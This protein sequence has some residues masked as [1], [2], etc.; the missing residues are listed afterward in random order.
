MIGSLVYRKHRNPGEVNFRRTI[1]FIC[2]F[3][4]DGMFSSFEVMETLAASG[5]TSQN[6]GQPLTPG[7]LHQ[8]FTRLGYRRSGRVIGSAWW[9]LK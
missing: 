4:R 9:Y 6:N 7:F 8:W 2:R 3:S 5:V 1:G